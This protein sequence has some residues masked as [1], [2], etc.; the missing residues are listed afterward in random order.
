[1]GHCCEG[2]ALMGIMRRLPCKRL[3]EPRKRKWRTELRS[4][5]CA[6][7]QPVRA[8]RGW[9]EKVSSLLWVLKVDGHLASGDCATRP[10]AHISESLTESDERIRRNGSLAQ[11]LP[12]WIFPLSDDEG[13]AALACLTSVCSASEIKM[14]RQ[15]RGLTTPTPQSESSRETLIMRA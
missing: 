5:G 8:A 2:P 3:G 7:E 15:R 9:P 13:E 4:S 11:L 14:A 1:M 10:A 6:S 12:D